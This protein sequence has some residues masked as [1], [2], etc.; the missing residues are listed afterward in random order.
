MLDEPYVRCETRTLVFKKDDDQIE[1]PGEY[2]DIFCVRFIFIYLFIL[3]YFIFFFFFF[4][5]FWGGGVGGGRGS[6]FGFQYFLGVFRGPQNCRYLFWV[7]RQTKYFC[8]F[9][10]TD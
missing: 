3:F 1:V 6:K 10:G 4:F 2:H 9:E 7:V 5:F 8:I